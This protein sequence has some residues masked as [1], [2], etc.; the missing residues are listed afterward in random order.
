MKLSF[1]EKA[2]LFLADLE[3]FRMASFSI[4]S[5]LLYSAG[6]PALHKNHAEMIKY[7]ANRRKRIKFQN[8]LY[9]MVKQKILQKRIE[10]KKCGYLLTPEGKK[11][12]FKLKLKQLK[13]KKL[14]DNRW[15]MVFFD[16]PEKRRILRDYLR[17]MLKN[18]GFN[19]LQKSIWVSRYDI[20]KEVEI[21]LNENNLEKLVHIMIIE[22]KFY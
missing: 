7:L 19:Q 13:K 3:D 6:H 18:I 2:L 10:G 4:N 9:R 14:Q 16:I 5:A 21:F 15:L 1:T 22:K 12:I 20:A 17:D 11:E 8:T